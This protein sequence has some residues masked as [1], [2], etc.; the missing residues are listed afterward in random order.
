MTD[1]EYARY[2]P[3]QQQMVAAEAV[4]SEASDDP[5]IEAMAREW[6]RSFMPGS[7]DPDEIVGRGRFRG[8]RWR[9]YASN[10]ERLL[11]A[12]DGAAGNVCERPITRDNGDYHV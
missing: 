10:M 3:W 1:E 6:C 12:A 5:R 4:V 8:P 9:G 7:R 2:S 11:R